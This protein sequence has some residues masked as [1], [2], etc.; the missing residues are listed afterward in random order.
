MGLMTFIISTCGKKH[1]DVIM[2]SN[3]Y[4]H[5]YLNTLLKAS[6]KSIQ[7]LFVLTI[8]DLLTSFGITDLTFLIDTSPTISQAEFDQVID[9]VF[10]I[11]N[12]LTIGERSTLLME[13]LLIL[14][15]QFSLQCSY[16]MMLI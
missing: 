11:T 8:Q 1:N 5:Q 10:N 2:M 13:N 3:K 7:H 16:K 6:S 9:F 15:K 14:Y 4:A 12:S